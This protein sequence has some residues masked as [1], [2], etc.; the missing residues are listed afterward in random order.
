M[1]EWALERWKENGMHN[2]TRQT[3]TWKK[4]IST[5]NIAIYFEHCD[6][7]CHRVQFKKNL[8]TSRAIAKANAGCKH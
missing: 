6:I 4:Y 8:L 3:E 2:Q 1:N 5:P 7:N